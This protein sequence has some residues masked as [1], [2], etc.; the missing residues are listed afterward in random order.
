MEQLIKDKQKDYWYGP[1]KK[2]IVKYFCG[3]VYLDIGCNGGF[4]LQELSTNN[5][6]YGI[7]LDRD[8]LAKADRDLSAKGIKHKFFLQ[9]AKDYRKD[10]KEK[11]DCLIC[12]DV[13]EHLEEETVVLRNIYQY[14]KKDG[15][16]ILTV[17]ALS[18]LYNRRDKAV[19]HHRR[20]N[21]KEII[22]K[23]QTA[24]L[25]IEKVRYWNLLLLP[26][27]FTAK[28]FTVKDYDKRE[29]PSESLL[30]IVI[31]KILELETLIPL[32]IGLT[33]L[34]IAKK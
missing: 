21:K 2:L 32:P 1:R 5:F 28:I 19:G 31:K 27:V 20:Y 33:I 10:L 26:V 29:M 18:W 23:I 17:P 8:A 25:S 34:V 16:L 9:D 3:K 30:R 7:D 12:T 11:I 14:L 15:R 22:R 6:A 4:L 24:G 13:L